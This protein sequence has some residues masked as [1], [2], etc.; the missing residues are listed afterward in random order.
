MSYCVLEFE[1]RLRVELPVY[2]V[3]PDWS[4]ELLMAAGV[5][6]DSGDPFRVGVELSWRIEQRWTSDKTRSAEFD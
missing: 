6:G 1:E 2:F 4:N 3:C 5:R